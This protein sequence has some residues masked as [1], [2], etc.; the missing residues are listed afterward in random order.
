MRIRISIPARGCYGDQLGRSCCAR[1]RMLTALQGIVDAETGKLAEA[2]R[3]LRLL[4]EVMTTETLHHV[5]LAELDARI[6][7]HEGGPVK[8]TSLGLSPPSACARRT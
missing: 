6:H 2:K 3:E 8:E 7:L 1:S 5:L 4:S